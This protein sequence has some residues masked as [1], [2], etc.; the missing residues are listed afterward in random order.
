MLLEHS[1]TLVW[2]GISMRGAREVIISWSNEIQHVLCVCV[3]PDHHPSQIDSVTTH[4]SPIIAKG[5]M[6]S[7][8]D[9][10]IWVCWKY[11]FSMFYRLG[12]PCY[13]LRI[14][15]ID[16]GNIDT[17]YSVM[18]GPNHQFV[19]WSGPSDGVPIW[20][21]TTIWHIYCPNTKLH[22][23]N[24]VKSWIYSGVTRRSKDE[25]CLFRFPESMC[26]TWRYWIWLWFWRTEFA[27]TVLV[28]AVESLNIFARLYCF[29]WWHWWQPLQKCDMKYMVFSGSRGM[30]VNL[31]FFAQ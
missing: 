23:E 9:R 2:H 21:I 20:E 11:W 3:G 13:G 16:A 19:R 25:I 29:K 31:H 24:P 18:F 6:Q 10:K 4:L 30:I 26:K 5:A 12:R 8:L 22:T 28:A 15:Q 1:Q 7:G 14:I 27:I 17:S